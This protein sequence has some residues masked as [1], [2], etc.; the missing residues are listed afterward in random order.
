MMSYL[1]INS[2][3]VPSSKKNRIAAV[4]KEPSLFSEELTDEEVIY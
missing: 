4:K 2:K 3:A 1:E